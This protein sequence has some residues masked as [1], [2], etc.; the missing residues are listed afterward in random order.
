MKPTHGR[1]AIC[2]S[3]VACKAAFAALYP[4]MR[5]PFV[6]WVE[7]GQ[8]KAAIVATAPAEGTAAAGELN[9]WLR[10]ITDVELPTH[11]T[12]Q[13]GRPCVFL[14]G[15]QA[16]DRLSTT[17][18]EL[19][20]GDQGYVIRT[21]GDDL[22]IAGE[23]SLGTLFGL[24]AFLEHY[25]GCRWFWPVKSG[26]VA[27]EQTV[28]RVGR[29]D[30]VSKPDFPI[31]WIIKSRAC[32]RF[33]RC[34]VGIS[35]PDDFRIHWF[36]HTYL[37][38]VE[39]S[40]Y[41]ETHPEY[42]ADLGGTRADPSA[43]GRQVNLCTTNPDVVD[44]A[45]AKIDEVMAA[46]PS[47]DMISVDPMDTQQFCQCPAC[48]QLQD[49]D[50]AYEARNSRLVFD[51]TNRVAERVARK[52]PR[53]LIKTIAYHTYLAPPPF[54]MHDNVVIQFCRFM[55]HNHSLA[56]PGCPE[57]SYFNRHL[58]AWQSVCDRIMFYEYYYKA[59]W[60]GLPWPIVHM[61]RTDLPYLLR[62]R[63]TGIAT[64]WDHNYANNG[65]GQ[66]VATKLLWDSSLDVD[67]LMTDFY[68]KAYVE[69]AAAMRRYHER[70]ENAMAA[71]GLHVAE[72]RGYRIMWRFLS[73]ELLAGC[74]ADIEA[75]RNAARDEGAAQRVE[76]M[77]RGFEY[78]RLVAAYLGTVASRVE[79]AGEPYW[80]GGE[81]K[82]ETAGLEE[83]CQPHVEELRRFLQSEDTVGA[84]HGLFG[85]E[86]ALLTPK[87]VAGSWHRA[88]DRPAG[89]RLTKPKWLEVNT[90]K[91][92][93]SSPD[94]VALWVYGNDIDWVPDTGAEHTVMC[95][96]VGGEPVRIGTM[97][98]EDRRGDRGNLA[99]V[100]RGID[101]RKLKPAPL[102]LTIENP[103]GGPYA[104]RIFAIYVMPDDDTSEDEATRRVQQELESVRRR[105][106]GFVEFGFNGDMSSEGDPLEAS[107]ELPGYPVESFDRP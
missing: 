55:C 48:R 14:G 42:Y 92:S 85:Y 27:P 79:G 6:T 75:A 12:P 21:V 104:T 29:I 100:F 57:S 99:F 63:V 98:R 26:I 80:Y 81:G 94:T 77:A 25:L 11:D 90:Q 91:L 76:L 19:G 16:W 2:A 28:L 22:V 3:L 56:E 89:I 65:I 24:Y 34:G 30:E 20:L 78:A 18:K 64:Q 15:K 39:P 66:Y 36:V 84:R 86:E 102:R 88:G 10:R 60:C 59:S 93:Q 74:A 97:G 105:A 4:E 72:Q 5:E 23:T 62:N 73:P 9:W 45:V 40:R 32:A 46:D 83:A 7:G 17:A 8:P 51:F 58:L 43:R 82:V 49:S 103:P 67:E 69:A 31:R 68:E 54:R 37:R 96:G 38:L 71:S 52:H 33:N 53:L 95:E 101:P 44:A 1:L 50:A 13:A 106:A 107:L 35:E 87:Q 70:L 47:I 61:L 41:W